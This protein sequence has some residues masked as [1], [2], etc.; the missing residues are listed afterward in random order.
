[1]TDGSGSL[2]VFL[3]PQAGFTLPGA[4]APGHSFKFVGL[5]VPTGTGTWMLK[6]R[7][8]SDIRQY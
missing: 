4:F 5:L 6:P 2:V 3:D 8:S 1:V 7:S